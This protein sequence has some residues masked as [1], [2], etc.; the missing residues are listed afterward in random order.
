MESLIIRG[1]ATYRIAKA[2]AT[3][4]GAFQSFDTFREQTEAIFGADSWVTRGVNCPHCVSF[5]VSLV[6]T[7]AGRGN[8]I[9]WLAT[10]GIASFLFT[11][12]RD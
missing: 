3:E 11:Q 9:Q 12:E 6:I 1:L 8:V 2:I 10:A 7:L 5:W 4:E